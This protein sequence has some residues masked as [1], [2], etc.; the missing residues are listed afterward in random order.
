MPTGAVLAP[1]RRAALLAW[2]AERE[3]LV[4][5]DDYDGEYRYDREPVGALQG[6]APE[7]VAYLGSASKT[8]A[9]ALRL[10]WL[11]LPSWLADT[12]GEEKGWADG[13]SPVL[14]QLALADFLERGELDRHLR[15][16]RL[17]YRRRRD[18]LV[19]AIGDAFPGARVRGV[20]A[21]LHVVAEPVETVDERA[22]RA[23]ARERSVAV[24]ALRDRGRTLLVL[25]YANMPEPAAAL[26][27]G[28]LRQAFD[29]VLAARPG[30]R[31]P[32]R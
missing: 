20:A 17:R 24:V 19:A 15:R 3:A 12:I 16:A 27:A 21:G 31:G 30:S 2:A 5:E 14:E 22:L 9:P 32:S 10:G 29:E 6:L 1:D 4:I 7:R 28:E 18:A 23:A 26:A 8:L 11:M 13:G 25:G